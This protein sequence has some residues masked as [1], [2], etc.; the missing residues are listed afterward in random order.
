MDDVVTRV[1]IFGDCRIQGVCLVIRVIMLSHSL[2]HSL[3]RLTSE[4]RSDL[5]TTRSSA[6]DQRAS[7]SRPSSAV[8]C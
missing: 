4:G 3:L 1:A 2:T 8:T 7:A 5:Q 6:H